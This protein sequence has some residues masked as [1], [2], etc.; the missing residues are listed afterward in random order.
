MELIEGDSLAR[1]LERDGAMDP[2]RAMDITAQVAAGLAAAH[3]VGL[4]HRDIK[5][6]NVLLN[7]AGVVKITDFGIA[8]TAGSAPLTQT[9]MIFGTPSYLAPERASGVQASE[10]T[11]LYALGVVVYECLSG[12]PPF[13]GTAIEVALAHR[14]RRFPPLPASVP[15]E[16]ARL[17]ADL[18]AK[19]PAH[20]PASAAEVAI[21]AAELRDRLGAGGRGT[22]TWPRLDLPEPGVVQ[23]PAAMTQMFSS[24]PEFSSQRAGRR[25]PSWPLLVGAAAVGVAATLIAVVGANVLGASG[26]AHPSNHA[27]STSPVTAAYV[28]VD[29]TSLV[30]ETVAAASRQLQAQGLVVRVRWQQT[31]GQPADAQPTDGQQTGRV[32]SIQPTGRVKA[33]STVTIIGVPSKNHDHGHGHDNGNG[34]SGDGGGGGGG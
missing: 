23:R 6:A 18:T 30:G 4:I 15:G 19:H 10:A 5:P 1:L 27:G 21:R 13:G 12:T 14:E 26:P 7:A 17:V 22:A 32:V 33:G 16:V 11:D 28:Y 20:R 31:D 3:H 24:Q 2:A 25:R 29:G 9:G 8:Y 34:N